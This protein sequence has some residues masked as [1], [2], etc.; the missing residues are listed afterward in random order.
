MSGEASLS[1]LF[2]RLKIIFDLLVQ[3]GSESGSTRGYFLVPEEDEW[4]KCV[5]GEKVLQAL[6]CN[7]LISLDFCEQHFS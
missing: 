7:D 2:V 5:R 1:K 4:P 6:K 3:D